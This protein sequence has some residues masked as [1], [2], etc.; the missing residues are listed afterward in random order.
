[1]REDI[2]SLKLSMRPDSR[3]WS[4]SVEELRREYRLRCRQVPS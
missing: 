4:D 3:S 2:D 1:M